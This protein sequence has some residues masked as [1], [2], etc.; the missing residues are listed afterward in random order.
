MILPMKALSECK[1]TLI[2]PFG[3][4]GR[5]TSDELPQALVI[6]VIDKSTATLIILLVQLPRI[7]RRGG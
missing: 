2:W 5:Q 7:S 6:L 1:K 3:I 4:I